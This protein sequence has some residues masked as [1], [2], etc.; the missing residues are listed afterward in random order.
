MTGPAGLARC[1]V[2]VDTGAVRTSISPFLL[3]AV[4]YELITSPRT[5]AV[6]SATGLTRAPVFDSVQVMALGER[7]DLD[8]MALQ[9]PQGLNFQGLLGLDFFRGTALIIDFA[10][11]FI[12]LNR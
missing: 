1:V 8:V 3:E 12:E 10:N 11:G 5:T 9:L 4:G 2:A 6:V 7:R